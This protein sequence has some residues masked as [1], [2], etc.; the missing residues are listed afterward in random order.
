[1]RRLAA[2]FTAA[3]FTAA[4]ASLPA[5]AFAHPGH[6]ATQSASVAHY[7]LE[8]VHAS[9][10]AALLT[11]SAISFVLVRRRALARRD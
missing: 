9:A 11:L 4:A 5:A 8:P 6:G 3:L 2:L 7:L 10:L 1:M